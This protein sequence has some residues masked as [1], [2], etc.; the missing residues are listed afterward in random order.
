M[1]SRRSHLPQHAHCRCGQWWPLC[2]PGTWPPSQAASWPRMAN[3]Q[4]RTWPAP[5]NQPR[6]PTARRNGAARPA[7]AATSYLVAR[8]PTH[9]AASRPPG[10]IPVH[11]PDCGDTATIC[12]SC[13]GKAR[14]PV[15]ERS[16]AWEGSLSTQGRLRQ[17]GVPVVGFNWSHLGEGSGLNCGTG[18]WAPPSA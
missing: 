10:P 8:A 17:P 15:S 5:W 14:L 18:G 7:R 1:V 2:P 4:G 9:R 3:S 12:G 13:R 6:H 11:V 16:C